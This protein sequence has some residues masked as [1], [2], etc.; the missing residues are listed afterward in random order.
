MAIPCK[1][2]PALEVMKFTIL[3]DSSVL[4]L[5]TTINAWIQLKEIG[6]FNTYPNLTKV[7]PLFT[8]RGSDYSPLLNVFK[9]TLYELCLCRLHND[10]DQSDSV[11]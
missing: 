8:N 9:L 4:F 2:T 10:F 1:R 5:S 6:K 3:L 7:R 11:L